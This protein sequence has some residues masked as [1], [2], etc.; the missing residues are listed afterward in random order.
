MSLISKILTYSAH[1]RDDVRR[2]ND[3]E[4]HQPFPMKYQ[5]GALVKLGAWLLET[6]WGARVVMRGIAVAAGSASVWLAA[7][8]AGSHTESMVAG[9]VSALTF[10]SEILIS[11]LNK[12]AGR[13]V[14]PLASARS[15]NP[16]YLLPE[17]EEPRPSLFG[18]NKDKPL[19]KRLYP[20]DDTPTE[21][22]E[23]PGVLDRI[24]LPSTEELA[25][26]VKR[27]LPPAPA[28][29][30]QELFTVEYCVP[31]RGVKDESFGSRAAALEFRDN[32][33]FNGWTAKLLPLFLALLLVGCV[34]D[35]ATGKNRW[36]GPNVSFSAGYK[37]VSAGVTLW[38][39]YGEEKK[40][41]SHLPATVEV[42]GIPLNTK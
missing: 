5:P 35:P 17:A 23:I 37:G 19:L 36:A 7:H 27:R 38:G 29:V 10:L 25:A 16:A 33:R 39:F 30:A 13:V 28:Q 22:I 12:K 26:E 40:P 4:T 14:N 11:W 34:R 3:P 2:A 8:G 21:R 6:P 20:D 32:C 42:M 18:E 1:A 9:L 41:A 24:P 15:Y 31:G